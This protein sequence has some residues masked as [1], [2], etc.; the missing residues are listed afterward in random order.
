MEFKKG[1]LLLEEEAK[2][3]LLKL[4]KKYQPGDEDPSKEL[5]DNRYSFEYRKKYV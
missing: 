3:I 5:A 4:I 2:P 1:K